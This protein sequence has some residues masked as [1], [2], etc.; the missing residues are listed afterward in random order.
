MSNSYFQFKQFTVH[1]DR[2]AMKVCTDACLFGA[3]IPAG[4]YRHILDIGTGTG[5]LSLMLAQKIPE[6]NIDAVEIDADAATQAK[7]NF[8]ASPWGESLQ[9]CHTDILS[10]S[11]DKPYNL[12]I[13][14]PP[15]FEGDLQSDDESRNKAKHHTS[16]N[17]RQLLEVA[18]RHLEP[19]G[20]FAILLPY[21]RLVYFEDLAR[22][23]GFH[24]NR[25]ILIRQT[26]KHDF[27][28]AILFLSNEKTDSVTTEMSIRGSN[29]EYSEEFV[30]LLRDYYL[31]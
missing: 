24:V 19:D 25:K 26:P 14:N 29:N 16:L 13:S 21:H 23:Y 28:R 30:G 6:A 18:D 5:L 9:V 17:L 8:N 31:K 1:Q 20:I 10:Y 2:C 15:F 12:I 11:A 7:E 22:E 27:F 3:S 4:N